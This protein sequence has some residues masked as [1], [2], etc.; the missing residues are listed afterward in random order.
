MFKKFVR[1]MMAL[2]GIEAEKPGN[3]IK[4]DGDNDPSAYRLRDDADDAWIVIN[5]IE[6]HVRKTDNGVVV[7]LYSGDEADSVA[8]TYAFFN[9]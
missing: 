2:V 7:D 3:L 4:E 1:A 6:A 8:S 9:E 5:G